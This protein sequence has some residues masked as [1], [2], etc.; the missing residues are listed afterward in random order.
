[1]ESLRALNQELGIK[2]LARREQYRKLLIEN[3]YRCGLLPDRTVRAPGLRI[4]KQ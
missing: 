1:M 4:Y 2:G 3:A